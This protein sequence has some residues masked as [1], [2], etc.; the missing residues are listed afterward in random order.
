MNRSPPSAL[1]LG[2][3]SELQGFR[4]GPGSLPGQGGREREPMPT[5]QHSSP[6]THCPILW[7][8][9]KKQLR[10]PQPWSFE[11]HVATGWL[12]CCGTGGIG[13]LYGIGSACLSFLYLKLLQLQKKE[14]D[15]VTTWHR[16]LLE[17]YWKT[18]LMSLHQDFT[19]SYLDILR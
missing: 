16:V 2:E 13:R 5:A 9:T 14:D 8:S 17:L 6:T 15:P 7:I 18:T 3:V 4:W 19:D 1:Q 10:C 12:L 11:T